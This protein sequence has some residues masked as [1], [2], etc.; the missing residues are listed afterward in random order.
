MWSEYVNG[1]TDGKL[2]NPLFSQDEKD[3]MF[4]LSKSAN[5]DEGV[6][7]RIHNGEKYYELPDGT[8]IYL[9]KV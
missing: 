4:N 1:K 7:I 2:N 5:T 8:F 3:S 9:G 6:K